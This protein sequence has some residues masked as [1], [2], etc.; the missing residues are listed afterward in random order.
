MQH[1]VLDAYFHYLLFLLESLGFISIRFFNPFDKS[2]C[3]KKCLESP[4]RYSIRVLG[5]VLLRFNRGGS[6]LTFLV[7]FEQ[8]CATDWFLHAEVMWQL[9]TSG[10]CVHG[11]HDNAFKKA[12]TN[13]ITTSLLH[14]L[15]WTRNIIALSWNVSLPFHLRLVLSSIWKC[16]LFYWTIVL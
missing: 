9:W 11:Y 15:G 12:R 5:L 6:G 3:M 8:A 2:Q 13:H 10:G 14:I 1:L 16:F 7:F 4:L